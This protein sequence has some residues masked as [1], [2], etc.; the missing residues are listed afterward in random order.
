MSKI[1]YMC[2]WCG[3]KEVRPENMGKPMPGTCPKRAKTRDGKSMP[4]S[5][6][7]NRKY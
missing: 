1:E 2:R 3:R 6:T 7:V 5:W 4:H